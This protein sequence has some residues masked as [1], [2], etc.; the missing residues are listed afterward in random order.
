MAGVSRLSHVSILWDSPVINFSMDECTLFG[1][2]KLDAYICE[3]LSPTDP[4]PS[5]ILSEYLERDVHLIMK[6]PSLRPCPPTVLFPEL[7]APVRFQVTSNPDDRL[8]HPDEPS[9]GR[10][11]IT[12]S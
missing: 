5:Q 3:A 2:Y 4:S 12:R 9:S 1:V 10:L 6:G 11:P 7:K 8:S